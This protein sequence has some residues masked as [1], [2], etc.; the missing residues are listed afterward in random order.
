MKLVI[1]SKFLYYTELRARERERESY[2]GLLWGRRKKRSGRNKAESIEETC[3]YNKRH[4]WCANF[5]FIEE[6]GQTLRFYFFVRKENILLLILLSDIFQQIFHI[7]KKI[8]II[9][10]NQELPINLRQ[11]SFYQENIIFKILNVDLVN[12]YIN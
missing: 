3:S 10:L 9:L 11:L 6:F 1:R 7:K 2:K 5:F 8:K 4:K 12:N